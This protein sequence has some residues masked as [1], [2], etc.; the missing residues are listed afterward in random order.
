MKMAIIFVLLA[1]GLFCGADIVSGGTASIDASLA[2]Q[3]FDDL[4]K[5]SDA[6][7]GRFWGVPLYGPTLF[8]DPDSRVIVANQSDKNGQLMA[9]NGIYRGTLEPSVNISNTAIEWSGTLWT[10][11]SWNAISNT[12]PYD[13]AKLLI[14]ESWHRVQNEIGIPSTVTAN[15][16]LDEMNGRIY[17]VLEFRALVRALLAKE[18]T[19]QKDAIGDALTFRHYRQSLFTNNNENAFERHEGMAEYTGL[20]LCGL[21]DSLLS[22]VAA[23]KLQLGE[24]NDGFANSFAYLT[25]PA[26]GLLLDCHTSDWRGKVRKGANLPDLLAAA[27]NYRS[28]SD[29]EQL[30]KAAELAGTKYEAAKLIASETA[31]TQQQGQIVDA[32]RNRLLSEGRLIIPNIN[33]NFSYDPREKLVSL[34]TTG[35]I[36]KTMRLTGD[37]GILEVTNG[38]LRT[39]DWQYFIAVAPGPVT[40]NPVTW[41]GYILQLNPG[42]Q[43]VTKSNKTFVIEKQ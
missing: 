26:L 3:Y 22:R 31:Q 36:C 12:D 30:Q 37:F 43:I 16:H 41:D 10:M 19:E 33:V 39:N 7:S 42:W 15:V 20:K 27:V 6:D 5:I 34:D 18:P 4:K 24:S 14:H 28:P 1:I 38:I 13:R 17:L 35:V 2:R 8:V 40:G 32:F 21:P 25:G 11:V 23:K 29:N 9:D